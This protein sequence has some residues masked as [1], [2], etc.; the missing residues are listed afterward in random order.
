MLWLEY[1]GRGTVPTCSHRD[2]RGGEGSN[3]S[4]YADDYYCPTC[5][6]EIEL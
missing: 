3:G 6:E 2:R 1:V 5:G 4:C